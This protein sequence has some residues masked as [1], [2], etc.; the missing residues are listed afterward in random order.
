[1]AL[2][3]HFVC[4]RCQLDLPLESQRDWIYNRRKMLWD[5]HK[6]LVSIAALT[7]YD[8]G[9][10]ASEIV[11]S[12][13]FRQQYK[14]GEWMGQM[15]VKMLRETALFEGVDCL[16][17]IPLTDGRKHSRGFNQAEYIARGMATELHIPVRCHVLRRLRERES[18]T[19]FNLVERISNADHVFSL[20]DASGL[21]GQHVM[22]VDDVMTTGTTMLGAIDCLE[23]V[24]DIRIS[25]FTWA[26]AHLTAPA[27]T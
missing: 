1:M 21:R 25:T 5:D 2:H 12:L 3:E 26:W 13:K 22:I 27:H 16:I 20:A 4:A 9:N 6:Q 17:P 8:R 11:R 7:R 15:A 10:I 24:P 23:T 19:H 14:L 18:Q